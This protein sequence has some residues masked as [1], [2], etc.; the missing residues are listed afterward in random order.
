MKFASCMQAF[1]RA[2]VEPRDAASKPDHS[3]FASIQV[4]LIEVSDL[5]FTAL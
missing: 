3:E 4:G 2:A 5:Q 1:G